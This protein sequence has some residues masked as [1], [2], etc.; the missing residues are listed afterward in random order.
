MFFTVHVS[1][2]KNTC[3]FDDAIVFSQLVYR[4]KQ[5]TSNYPFKMKSGKHFQETQ[6][7]GTPCFVI[8]YMCM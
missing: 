6:R 5:Q 1:F 3:I 2:Y 8:K 7:N 4:K